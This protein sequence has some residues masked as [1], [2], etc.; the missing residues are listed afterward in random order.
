MMKWAEHADCV[1]YYDDL[2]TRPRQ[3]LTELSQLTG[4]NLDRMVQYSW[5]RNS[6][7]YRRA[8]PGNWIN[9]FNGGHLYEFLR[10]WEPILHWDK[11]I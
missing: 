9:Y 6:I 10:L 7:T 11:T 4:L 1:I 8:S 5:K 3:A 2:L